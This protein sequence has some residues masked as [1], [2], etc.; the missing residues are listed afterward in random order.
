MVGPLIC[1][2]KIIETLVSLYYH[3]CTVLYLLTRVPQ[4]GRC[5]HK[6]IYKFSIVQD[7]YYHQTCLKCNLNLLF[8]I[9]E[10]SI[11]IWKIQ[12]FTIISGVYLLYTI[13][14][15]ELNYR[16]ITPSK[17]WLFSLKLVQNIKDI[18]WITC[19]KNVLEDCCIYKH[20]IYVILNLLRL[21]KIRMY[22]SRNFTHILISYEPSEQHCSPL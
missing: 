18:T 19:I 5:M 7:T 17:P 1:Q 9:Y 22:L 10:P 13:F 21:F 20:T 16:Y 14:Q 3:Q 6:F 4:C 12:V 2:C 11:W 8:Y 15:Y